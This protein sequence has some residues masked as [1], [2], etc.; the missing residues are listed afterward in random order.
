MTLLLEQSNAQVTLE[1]KAFLA[2]VPTEQLHRNGWAAVFHPGGPVVLGR[3]TQF[4]ASAAVRILTKES[5][6]CG[7]RAGLTGPP[8]AAR[9]GLRPPGTEAERWISAGGLQR[10]GLQGCTAQT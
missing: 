6:S 7:H 9:P 3:F 4:P 1:L 5:E 10:R 2:Y 8:G